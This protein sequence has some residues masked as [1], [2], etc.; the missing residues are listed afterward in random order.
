MAPAAESQPSR[1]EIER[2]KHARKYRNERRKARER[3]G[4]ISELNITA[5]MDMMTIILVF[6][7][8]SYSASAINV[9]MGDNLAIP[10]SS[11][12]L[13]PQENITVTVAVNEVSVNDR[14]VIR[15]ADGMGGGVVPPRFKEG[16]KADAFYI[17]SLY[18][19]LK[20]EVDKQ[21]YIAQYNR[22]APFTGRVNVVVDKRVPYRT[23]MEILYTAGQAELGEYKF[24]VLKR[25]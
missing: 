11:T 14:V 21:K 10:A 18:D 4:E 2:D 16:G 8:K 24:M 12:Q 15:G 23:L 9:N 3:A 19:G 20:K 17:G 25:E 6:L 7:L 22:N 5:M 13:N 1:E